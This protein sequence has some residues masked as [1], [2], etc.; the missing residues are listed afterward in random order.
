MS[1]ISR[2]TSTA[3][4]KPLAIGLAV[5]LAMN[6][7]AGLWIYAAWANAGKADAEHRAELSERDAALSNANAEA[8]LARADRM[9]SLSL[10]LNAADGDRTA[11]VEKMARRIETAARAYSDAM[12]AAP[13]DPRCRLDA[14]RVDAINKARGYE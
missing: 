12:K 8:I 13:L 11:A 6:V 5:S 3:A 1:I 14:A 10:F 2:A 7:G 9:A 4:V